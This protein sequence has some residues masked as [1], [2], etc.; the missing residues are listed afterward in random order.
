MLSASATHFRSYPHATKAQ[1]VDRARPKYT[2]PGVV[3][4]AS[5]LTLLLLFCAHAFAAPLGESEPI[6]QS[7]ASVAQGPQRIHASVPGSHHPAPAPFEH[8][9]NNA[10]R[11][12]NDT[13]DNLESHTSWTPWLHP[14]LLTE[15]QLSAGTV[16]YANQQYVLGA[17]RKAMP[18]FVLYHAWK[19]FLA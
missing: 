11:E 15:I 4:F 1:V 19:S 6:G 16:W 17:H 10:T 14:G 7:L 2:K 9:N 18:L 3:F 8:T 5:W 13:N 12:V